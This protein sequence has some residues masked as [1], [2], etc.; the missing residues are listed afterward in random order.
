MT[1]KFIIEKNN[2]IFTHF[3]H[4][5]AHLTIGLTLKPHVYIFKELLRNRR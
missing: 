3:Q 5:V 4:F 1:V 2:I